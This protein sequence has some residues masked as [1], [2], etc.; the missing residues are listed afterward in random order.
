MTELNQNYRCL[1]C[2]NIASVLR[3]GQG[4]F[5]CCNQKMMLLRENTEEAS[6]EKHI[7]IIE[8]TA[9]GILV[10]VGEIDHPMDKDHYIEWIEAIDGKTRYIKYLQ[11][12][13]LAQAEFPIDNKD[14]KI[15]AY[16]NLHGSWKA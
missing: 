3:G 15:L 10:K 5:S 7:P 14:C 2:G 8:K 4:E 1:K 11:P 13:D 16:C 6:T 9:N 12:G